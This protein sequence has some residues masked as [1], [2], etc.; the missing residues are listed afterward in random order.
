MNKYVYMYNWI[1]LLYTWNE[2]NT[3]NQL[4]SNIKLKKKIKK[5]LEG[6]GQSGSGGQ[7]FTLVKGRC[8]SLGYLKSVSGLLLFLE[9]NLTPNICD[10]TPSYVYPPPLSQIISHAGLLPVPLTHYILSQNVVPYARIDFFFLLLFLGFVPVCPW[11]L[12]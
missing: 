12:S 5:R 9:W 1:T 10:L 2:H 8:K 6:H 3:I 11:D 4:Y 7:P